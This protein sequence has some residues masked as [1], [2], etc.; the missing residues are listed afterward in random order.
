MSMLELYKLAMALMGKGY[1]PSP[2]RNGQPIYGFGRYFP[3][4]KF[5]AGSASSKPT[6]WPL[7]TW[8]LGQVTPVTEVPL[9]KF[10]L[11]ARRAVQEPELAAQRKAEKRT[12]IRLE[13]EADR[14]A[15][16]V[17]TR[18][19]WLAAHSLTRSA[20]W[21]AETMSRATYYRRRRETGG[22]K[23]PNPALRVRSA[24]E[25]ST[26]TTVTIGEVDK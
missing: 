17:P 6:A 24:S 2:L 16:G 26:R 22:V 14:R 3:N 13:R 7:P 4:P 19:G 1:C 11:E 15:R 8:N 10:E 5:A 25:A 9:S 12:K 20:P 21:L 23:Y 18:A